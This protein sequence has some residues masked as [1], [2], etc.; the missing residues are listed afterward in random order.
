MTIL[1]FRRGDAVPAARRRRPVIG[2]TS[3]GRD[4]KRRFRLS[5]DYVD[6]VRA[7]GGI[8]IILPPEEPA[9]PETFSLL[10]GLILS[11]GG[12]IAPER[13]QGRAHPRVYNVDAQRDAY[14]FELCSLALE[15]G[16]PLLCICRGAQLLNV[17]LGGS[18]HPHIPDVV[19]EDIAHRVELDLEAEETAHCYHPVIVDPRSRLAETLGLEALELPFAARDGTVAGSAESS[20]SEGAAEVVTKASPLVALP[21]DIASWH[22]QA[23]KALGSGLRATAWA[24]DGTIE[25]FELEASGRGFVQA[26]QWHP[27]ITAATDALQQRLFE[28]LVEAAI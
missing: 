21:V 22:H 25:A 6:A 18:L 12:D 3:Y 24:A 4:E 7:A 13:Y 2:I 14:E 9:V 19:G 10:D 8:P 16:L 17:H 23:V 5:V 20:T 27:E 11:G 28:A 26:L 1:P 15:T